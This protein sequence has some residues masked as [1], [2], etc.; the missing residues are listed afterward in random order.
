MSGLV[1]I[2][3]VIEKN[4]I[5]NADLIESLT[6]VCGKGG[7]WNGIA[8]KE[9]KFEIGSLCNVYLQDSILPKLPEFSFMEKNQ[10]RVKMQRMRGVPS[11][12]LITKVKFSGNV[13]DDITQ[14]A[15]VTKYE[16]PI[17]ASLKGDVKGPRPFWIP[18]TDEQNFQ[19]VQ[20]SVETLIGKKFYSTVK[21]DGTSGTIYRKGDEFGCCGRNMEFKRSNANIFWNLCEKYDL[22][23]K[24][25]DN[26]VIQFEAVG[27]RIQKNPLK[28]KEPEMRC[29]DL[30]QLDDKGRF[31]EYKNG[32]DWLAFC[33]QFSI[34]HAKVLSM[35]EVFETSDADELRRMAEIK[36]EESG[37]TGEGIVI[38]SLY[39]VKVLG[40]RI[41]F[42]VINLNYK[43]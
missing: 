14:Q 12:V 2:G 34:P 18:K 25:P 24:L 41:S 4:P 33:Q 28:L 38:R 39:G 40:E 35:G 8:K 13:G 23:N 37:K 43:D 16:K 42:K 22:E 36:Y 17:S 6:V 32:I 9:D 21:Y 27:P 3:K 5:P 31:W 30:M 11:E 10:Y 15:G 7:K 20:L 19:A 26:T 1:Y 29:F